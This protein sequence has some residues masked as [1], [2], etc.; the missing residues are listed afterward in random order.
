MFTVGQCRVCEKNCLWI[1]FVDG[2]LAEL[3]V[4]SVECLN[5]LMEKLEQEELESA[6]HGE[7][8]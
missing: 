2:M 6:Q 4:C 3:E 7:Q 1:N 5:K 8:S